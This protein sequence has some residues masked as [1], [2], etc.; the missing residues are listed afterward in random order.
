MFNIKYMED[1]LTFI[2]LLN[3]TNKDRYYE[4]FWLTFKNDILEYV[5][6]ELKVIL[7]EKSDKLNN[8][9]SKKKI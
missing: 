9:Q 1:D 7:H 4:Y 3:T 6:E 5:N 8:L 2:Y